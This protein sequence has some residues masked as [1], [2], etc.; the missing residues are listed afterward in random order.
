MA[1]NVVDLFQEVLLKYRDKVQCD[2]CVQVIDII[3]TNRKFEVTTGKQYKNHVCFLRTLK[4]D[5]K[6]GKL[7]KDRVKY[8]ICTCIFNI[9]LTIPHS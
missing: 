6:K 5:Y 8:L 3:N 7:N 2:S 4:R 9:H 1:K